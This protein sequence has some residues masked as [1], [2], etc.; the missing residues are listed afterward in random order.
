VRGIRVL[1]ASAAIAGPLALLSA[2]GGSTVTA[3]AGPP[4]S[5]VPV[6]PVCQDGAVS[7]PIGG[8]LQL[9]QCGPGAAA[10]LTSGTALRAT[11]DLAFTAVAAGDAVVAVTSGPVCSAGAVCSHTRVQRATL[12]VTV[13]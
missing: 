6:R 7:L 12:H 4:S 11:G 9:D 1:L 13:Q 2:C 5:A 10:A 3:H 8:E